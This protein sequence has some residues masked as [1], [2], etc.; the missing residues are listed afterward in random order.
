[1][2]V[3][4]SDASVLISLGAV[5]QVQLLREFYHEI[6][7]PDAVWREVTVVAGSRP[8]APEAIQASQQRL[9][10]GADARQSRASPK[11]SELNF[12]RV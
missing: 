2:P 9:A 7:V 10:Q 4:V 1:M 3:V 6:V 11:T 8:G 12:E 5:R